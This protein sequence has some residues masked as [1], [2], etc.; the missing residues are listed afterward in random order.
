MDAKELIDLIFPKH[1]RTSCNDDNLYNG[2]NKYDKITRCSRC[3]L[4]SL[5]NDNNLIKIVDLD[6]TF[7]NIETL[8][9]V[10]NNEEKE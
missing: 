10:K 7:I 4:L 9:K 5:I 2:I 3:A 6:S 1:G 8:D